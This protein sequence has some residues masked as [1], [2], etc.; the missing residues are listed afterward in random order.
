[1]SSDVCDKDVRGRNQPTQHVIATRRVD[2]ET[3]ASFRWTREIERRH[4]VLPYHRVDLGGNPPGRAGSQRVGAPPRLNPD[5]LR[6][7]LGKLPGR[8]RSGDP[9]AE[10]DR[11]YPVQRKRASLSQCLLPAY[12][13]RGC[14]RGPGQASTRSFMVTLNCGISA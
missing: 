9:E 2:L 8:Y 4:R 6:P 11:P 14:A 1:M 5:D 10:F 13:R 3:D 12:T 7:E